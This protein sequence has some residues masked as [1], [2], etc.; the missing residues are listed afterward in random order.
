[1]MFK[2]RL[3]L[4]P[5]MLTPSKSSPKMVVLGEKGSVDVKFWFCDPQKAHPCTEPHPLTYF[6]LMSVV[7]SGL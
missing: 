2:S 6:V 1:M 7:A 5:L 3:L 4:A